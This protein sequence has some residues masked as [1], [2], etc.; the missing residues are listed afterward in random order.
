MNRKQRMG[1]EEMETGQFLVFAGTREGRELTE[2]LTEQQIP[3]IVCVATDYGEALL[4]E[5]EQIRVRTGR[6]GCGEMAALIR[7]ERPLAVIDATHPY[8]DAVTANIRRACEQEK[9]DVYRL[10][11]QE[12]VSEQTEGMRFFENAA[13]AADWLCGKQGNILLTT[14]MKELSVFAERP[15]LRDRLF[16]RTLPQAEV[17]A[18]IETYGLSGKQIICMQGPFSREMNAATLRMTDAKYLVT[19][20]S[21]R[22][23]GFGEKAEAARECGAVCL[24]IRRPASEQGFAADEV[25]EMILRLWRENSGENREVRDIQSGSV[26]EQCGC[27]DEN[28]CGSG[29]DMQI[30]R[31]TRKRGYQVLQE[32][33]HEISADKRRRVTIL[34]IGMGSE[35]NM[36][37]EAVAACRESDCIIGADRMLETLRRF[38]KPM[39][40]LYRSDEIASYIESHPEYRKF[41][42]AFSGD[43]GFYSGAR[44]LIEALTGSQSAQHTDIRLLC[45]ISSV[46]YFASR[47]RMAWED[48]ALVSSHGREQNL[49]SAVRQNRKVFTLASDAKSIRSIAEK[50]ELFGLGDVKIYVG[51]DLSYPTEHIYEG[52]AADFAFF[53]QTGVFSAVICNEQAGRETVTHGIPDEVFVRGNVPM[54]KEEVRSISV[55]KLRLTRDAIVYDVGAG[56]GS[57][58][59]ECA[60][61]ADR[62]RVYAIEWKEDAWKLIAENRKQFAVPN[63][64]IVAGRAPEKLNRLPAPTHAFIGGSGGSLKNILRTLVRKNPDVRIVINCITL[65]TVSEMMEAAKELRM[66]IEDITTVSIAK[67]KAAGA[68]HMMTAR[69]PVT[70]ITLQALR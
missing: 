31:D 24:V 45:G 39:A 46:V 58:S 28:A 57:V 65:E 49:V 63:L 66:E 9:T 55:S 22:I 14:G 59:V 15:E 43:I 13:G 2:F 50:L 54:T 41:A 21:G 70:I 4:T 7:E 8:A 12:S 47:L 61:M 17:F 62:G 11:R 18:Q 26:P 25:R 1:G 32:T 36:T 44:K 52:K 40:S 48:M 53:D 5:N 34:G 68:Y 60:R 67:S 64:E 51:A 23:G 3:A 27:E 10:L 6:M 33:P 19:K 16:V 29:R 30:G 35:D 56:T 38:E 69:N 37:V 20:E 42:V